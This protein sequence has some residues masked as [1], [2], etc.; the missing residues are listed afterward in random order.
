MTTATLTP[1]VKAGVS[2]KAFFKALG[3][4]FS[5]SFAVLGELMQNAHRARASSVHFCLEGDNL[6]VT[7]DV[8]HRGFPET[9]TVR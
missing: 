5:S 8:R 7:D 9:R 4:W 3:Q 1:T 6:V 2:E